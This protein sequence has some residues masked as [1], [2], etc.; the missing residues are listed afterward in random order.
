MAPFSLARPRWLPRVSSPFPRRALDLVN[1]AANGRVP[2]R[3]LNVPGAPNF[4]VLRVMLDVPASPDLDDA[5]AATVLALDHEGPAIYNIVDDEPV[6]TS[7]W[8]PELA[9][10]IGAK[11]P[12]HFPR[13][14]ARIFAG[15][16]AVMMMTESRGASNAKAKRELGWTLRYPSWRQ[17]FVEAY[18]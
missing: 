15:E 12:R 18:G 1:S 7:V 6:P 9:K 2:V 4:V 10:A 3:G 13:W 16:A 17:G 14:L 8:L 11:P 5:A